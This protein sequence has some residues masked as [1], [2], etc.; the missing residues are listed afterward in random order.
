MVNVNDVLPV[1]LKFEAARL[2]CELVEF[3]S[4][5]REARIPR[6]RKNP[7]IHF[8]SFVCLVAPDLE[9]LWPLKNYPLFQKTEV[10]ADPSSSLPEI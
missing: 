6:A 8:V 7:S 2:A 10:T 3:P 1:E 4:L 5:C 9:V